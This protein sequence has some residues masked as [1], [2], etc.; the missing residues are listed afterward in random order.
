MEKNKSTLIFSSR[1]D[2]EIANIVKLFGVTISHIN[3]GFSYFGF[4]LKPNKHR[5]GDCFWL[6]EKFQKRL[7][8]WSHRWLSLGDKF[9]L[10]QVVL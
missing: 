9:I 5:I 1:D 10:I 8:S 2:E 3:E 4:R 7:S 6:L